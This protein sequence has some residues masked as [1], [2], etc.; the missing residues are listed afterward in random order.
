[1]IVVELVGGRFDGMR[2]AVLPAVVQEGFLIVTDC[3][4]HGMDAECE[5]GNAMLHGYYVEPGLGSGQLV[6]VQEEE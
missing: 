5:C 4:Q 3:P 2:A 1:V 6:V